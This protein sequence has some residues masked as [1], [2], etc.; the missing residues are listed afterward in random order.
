MS[1]LYLDFKDRPRVIDFFVEYLDYAPAKDK[2][3]AQKIIH[4]YETGAK[5]SAD[6]LAEAARKFAKAVW[7]ARFAMNRYFAEE[8]KE[9]EWERI[10]STVRPSTAHLLKRF[11]QGT[12]S[13]S[14]DLTL[15][16]AES[17]IAF[18]E[19]ECLEIAEVRQQLRHD[20]W[21]DKFKTLG[22]YVKDGE[23][24][25]KSYLERLDK[26]RELAAEFS[27]DLQD[28]IY[29]K[30]TRYEDRIFFEG[31]V[32]PLQILDEEL[33]YYIDQKEISTEDA[34]EGAIFPS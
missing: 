19:E 24:E 12:G 7:P 16:H 14:L 31:E 18:R 27:R 3:A 5:Q 23:H 34:T 30:L 17:E 13:E 6:K 10:L 25:L 8:G 29:S 33:K 22:M 1:D 32:V 15:S 20:Y 26:L 28:E 21:R 4:Q 11:R 9:T 2:L